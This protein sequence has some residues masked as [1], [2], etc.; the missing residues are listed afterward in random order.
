MQLSYYVV[1]FVVSSENL[2]LEVFNVSE[3]IFKGGKESKVQIYPQKPQTIFLR[4]AICFVI[5]QDISSVRAA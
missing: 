1:A 2:P 4:Y 5:S 3:Y